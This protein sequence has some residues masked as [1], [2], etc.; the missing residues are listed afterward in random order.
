[1]HTYFLTNSYDYASKIDAKSRLASAVDCYT[2]HCA[3]S[4]IGPS[5]VIDS[6]LRIAKQY[7]SS[8]YIPVFLAYTAFGF[9]SPLMDRVMNWYFYGFWNAGNKDRPR[10]TL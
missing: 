1:M 9:A 8:R 7:T 4:W 5:L 2:W 3:A 10:L 6:S